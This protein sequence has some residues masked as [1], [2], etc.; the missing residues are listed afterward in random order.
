[1]ISSGDRDADGDTFAISG[2]K[3]RRAAVAEDF[4]AFRKGIPKGLNNGDTRKL[5]EEIKSNMP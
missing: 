4:D 3:M 1:V 2:T 5:M